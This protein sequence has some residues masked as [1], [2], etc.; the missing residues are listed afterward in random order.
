MTKAK[1]FSN[2]HLRHFPAKA[3]NFLSLGLTDFGAPILCAR[4]SS[5]I[6][7][8][9]SGSVS[10]AMVVSASNPFKVLD[11]VVGLVPVN[12]VAL[13]PVGRADE[14][15]GN[16]SVGHFVGDAPA[17]PENVRKVPVAT[18]QGLQRPSGP[19]ASFAAGN[20]LGS[21]A[22]AARTDFVDVFPF[23][24]GKPNL[25]SVHMQ[26]YTTERQDR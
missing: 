21:A 2:S 16:K 24:G 15:F 18:W 7:G 13:Q 19:L 8:S 6:S 10:V 11:R 12:M 22:S 5:V 25:R 17:I 4:Q 1:P 20:Q 14:G 9:Q 23:R 3:P 26:D